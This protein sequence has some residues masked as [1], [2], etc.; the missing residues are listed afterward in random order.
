MRTCILIR[1][2]AHPKVSLQRKSEPKQ[3]VSKKLLCAIKPDFPVNIDHAFGCSYQQVP[4][5]LDALLHL[6]RCQCKAHPR[7][8]GT[9]SLQ[10]TWSNGTHTNTWVHSPDEGLGP[11][12]RSLIFFLLFFSLHF[13]HCND[14]VINF[15]F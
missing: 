15:T 5:L 3:N 13:R 1:A 11:F 4:S 2:K 12:A 6:T 9:I 7:I 10:R 8:F 14:Q